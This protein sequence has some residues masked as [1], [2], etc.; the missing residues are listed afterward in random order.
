M[1]DF[2]SNDWTDGETWKLIAGLVGMA[3]LVLTVAVAGV[4]IGLRVLVAVLS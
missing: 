2:E 1:S 4:W 3:C